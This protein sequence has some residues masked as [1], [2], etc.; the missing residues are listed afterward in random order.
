MVV[1]MS[2]RKNARVLQLYSECC[3]VIICVPA[4]GIRT[5]CQFCHR[6]IIILTALFVLFH[7]VQKM[8]AYKF[9][10]HS[11]KR[12]YAAIILD[13]KY[14][15]S[16]SLITNLTVDWK[17]KLPAHDEGV[18][19]IPA[20][21]AHCPPFSFVTEL[22]S[23]TVGVNAVHQTKITFLTALNTYIEQ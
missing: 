21:I 15:V 10:H 4:P 1:F 17:P 2:P 23:T 5:R 14:D 19:L 20:I 9:A 22:H 8:H 6:I 16:Y 7:A 18:L 11:R 12:R 13:S 3:T